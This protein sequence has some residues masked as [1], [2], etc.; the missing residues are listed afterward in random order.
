MQ[1]DARPVA[2]V[3]RGTW[4]LAL[5]LAL[6]KRAKALLLD[7][8]LSGLDPQAAND[9]VADMQEVAGAGMAVL[10]VTHDVMRAAQVA[11]RIGIMRNGELVALLNGREISGAELER[12][13][14]EY[15]RDVA[16]V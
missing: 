12:I 14:I 16:K 9:F 3:H 6:V 1:K 11:D 7:E 4:K 13:Y 10:M 15:I 5:A 8:P 2:D